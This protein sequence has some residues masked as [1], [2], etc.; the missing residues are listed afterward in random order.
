MP[1]VLFASLISKEDHKTIC[2]YGSIDTPPIENSKIDTNLFQLTEKNERLYG[3]G[4]SENKGPLSCWLNALRI[5][6]MAKIEI[7]LNI[8][9]VIEGT[10]E[11]HSSSLDRAVQIKPEFFTDVEY[12]CLTIDKRLNNSPCLKYGFRGTCHFSLDINCGEKNVD[13]GSYGGAFQQSL[14]DAVNVVESFLDKDEKIII[15]KLMNDLA[16]LLPKEKIFCNEIPF[17]V[18]K[19]KEEIGT[20]RLKHK[21]K[22]SRLVMHKTR[23][24]SISV[25]NFDMKLDCLEKPNLAR[26]PNRV[27][28]KFS[29]R[30]VPNQTAQKT[31]RILDN[32]INNIWKA[33]GKVNSYSLNMDFGYDPWRQDP[34][35]PHYK[36]AANAI[37]TVYGTK[38]IYVCE[39]YTLPAVVVMTKACFDSDLL[40]LPISGPSDQ[41]HSNAESISFAD[42]INGVKLVIAY[43]CEIHDIQ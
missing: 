18:K 14:L 29:I 28:A 33:Y 24:P 22:N 3:S 20:Q 35:G 2:V 5:Y 19:L 23:L 25:H 15:P 1:P 31:Y 37:E 13:S 34:S 17:D 40:V 10:A 11:S 30:L 38:P 7:P 4:V 6:K 39:G 8:K 12:V 9:F 26:V 27:I 36:A 42:Y 16:S 43:M 32:H 21:E 41:L